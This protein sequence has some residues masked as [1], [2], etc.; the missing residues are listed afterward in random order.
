[1]VDGWPTVRYPML[2]KRAKVIHLS[3]TPDH[4]ARL[5][6]LA[7]H[8]GIGRSDA[9]RRMIDLAFWDLYPPARRPGEPPK[10]GE[11]RP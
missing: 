9:V 7:R 1:M 5:R 3:L 8:Y 10:L 11:G 2:M 6:E 4:D